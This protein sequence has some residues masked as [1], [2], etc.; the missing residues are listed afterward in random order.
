MNKR[1]AEK[2]AGPKG[3][4]IKALQK[5][6]GE[7]EKLVNG[8]NKLEAEVS[9]EVMAAGAVIAQEFTAGGGKKPA[10]RKGGGGRKKK[11]ETLA[12]VEA[13]IA[14]T[15]PKKNGDEYPFTGLGYMQ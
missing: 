5:L 15:P 8:L 7:K 13:E 3:H 14:K 12:G 9:K 2:V 4:L 11:S 1:Q 10:K 6:R